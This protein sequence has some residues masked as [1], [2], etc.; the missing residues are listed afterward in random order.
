M[1]ITKVINPDYSGLTKDG[2]FVSLFDTL[3]STVYDTSTSFL[4]T[5][6][7]KP[8]DS[9][10]NKKY[11]NKFKFSFFIKIFLYETPPSLMNKNL[12]FT[13]QIY[14]INLFS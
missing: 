2:F 4:L 13:Q 14:L 10:I 5:L 6:Y 12:S 1:L 3:L 8:F 9:K 11:L 7:P